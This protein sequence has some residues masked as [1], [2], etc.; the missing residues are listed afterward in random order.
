[1]A[2]LN[3]IIQKAKDDKLK[4]IA[5]K[6]EERLTMSTMVEDWVNEF[7]SSPEEYQKLLDFQADNPKISVG[8]ICLA[9][10]QYENPT[11]IASMDKWNK[12][13]RNVEKG[14]KGI[15]ILVPEKYRDENGV[16][17]TGFKV[18]RMFD[19]SQTNGQAL[20]PKTVLKDGG[21]EIAKAIASLVKYST[22]EIQTVD[23]GLGK[24]L[25]FPENKTIFCPADLPDT[26]MLAEL[27]RETVQAKIHNNGSYEGYAHEDCELDAESVSYMVCKRFGIETEKPDL[28]RF[29]EMYKDLDVDDKKSALEALQSMAETIGNRTEREIN[30]P[31]REQDKAGRGE[32]NIGGR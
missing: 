15:K 4:W 27:T 5:D 3:N 21:E 19:I 22:V 18:G 13:G 26:Q 7:T 14:E 1:M 6:K 10:A 8:N 11:K 24:A 30:P 25:Y 28:S 16:T 29:S 32:H 2:D 23:E 17:R 9:Y 12:L 31:E 20:P